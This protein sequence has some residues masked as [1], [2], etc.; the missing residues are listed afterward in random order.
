MSLQSTSADV[1]D[2]MARIREARNLMRLASNGQP[3]PAYRLKRH[4]SA[5]GIADRQRRLKVRHRNL[6]LARR[7]RERTLLAGFDALEARSLEIARI[8]R[9]TGDDDL[10]AYFNDGSG[11]RTVSIYN[12][13]A[14][15][16]GEWESDSDLIS[17]IDALTSEYGTIDLMREPEGAIHR[18]NGIL[19]RTRIRG[20]KRRQGPLT[21]ATA[22]DET[23]IVREYGET[24]PNMVRALT[25]TFIRETALGQTPAQTRQA[26]ALAASRWERDLSARKRLNTAAKQR[27]TGLERLIRATE[28]RKAKAA[29]DADYIRRM[30]IRQSAV[31]ET[32]EEARER[33]R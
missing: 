8:I 2:A 33:N 19:K 28:A 27:Q 18:G 5:K 14:Q 11:R 22:S 23:R 21:V 9:E 4:L 3:W 10:R 29:S 1:R 16:V 30:A 7:L 17:A 26:I 24:Y 20:I 32:P 12:A 13:T 25:V 31:I 6:V 15:G